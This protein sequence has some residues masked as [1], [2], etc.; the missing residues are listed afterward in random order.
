MF[1]AKRASGQ[2]HGRPRQ[3]AQVVSSFKVAGP[4]TKVC[5]TV[6]SEKSKNVGPG[7]QRMVRRIVVPRTRILRD[8]S[9]WTTSQ[10]RGSTSVYGPR[11]R[12]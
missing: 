8:A 12:G 4:Q 5:V 7:E 10:S 6:V 1:G 2:G 9:V 11:E 3:A